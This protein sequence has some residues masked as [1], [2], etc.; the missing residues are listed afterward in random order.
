MSKVAIVIAGILVAIMVLV[1]VASAVA[2]SLF[3][4]QVEKE[5]GELFGSIP[6]DKKEIV[7]EAD[8]AGLPRC[9]QKWLERSQVVGKEKIRTVRLKQSGVMRLKEDQPWMP[10][11][12]EQYFNVEEPGFVWKAKVKMNPLL[13]FSGRDRYFQGRGEMNIKVLSLLPVAAAGGSSEMD[14]STLLRYLAEMIWFPTAALNDYIKWEEIDANSA[15]ATMSYQ[16]V[17]GS[18]IYT[19]DDNGDAVSFFAKRYREVNGQYAL[20]PWGGVAKGYSEF[21]GIRIS[22]K[23]DVIWKLETG[24]FNWFQCDITDIEYNKPQL[25]Q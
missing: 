15:W 24:D 22:S 19:F 12:A 17:T 20:D 23:M 13:Y 18:G 5:V 1:F 4:R 6:E 14:Q 2:N 16:G 25:Y 11:E 7:A 10:F 3:E 8:L 21:N 9:V